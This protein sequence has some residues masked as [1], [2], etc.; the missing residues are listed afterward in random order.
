MNKLI[1]YRISSLLSFVFV[2]L[3][4]GYFVA[5]NPTDGILVIIVSLSSL[6]F[7]YC[8]GIVLELNKKTRGI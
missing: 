7:G 4:N 1:L 5:T 3:I 2:L 6:I 8:Y